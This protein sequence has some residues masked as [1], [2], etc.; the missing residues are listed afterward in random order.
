MQ[1]RA[2][3]GRD[4]VAK[5]TPHSGLKDQAPVNLHL[6]AEARGA[7]GH[8]AGGEGLLVR[9]G[10]VPGSKTEGL[11]CHGFHVHTLYKSMV[12]FTIWN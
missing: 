12:R 2:G 5:V 11:L 4:R 6:C 10:A 9:P 7:S 1:L 3:L 8:A